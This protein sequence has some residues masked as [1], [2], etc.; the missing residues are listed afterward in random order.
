MATIGT[1]TKNVDGTFSGAINTLSLNVK[2]A[3]FRPNDKSDPKSPDFRIFAGKA[4]LGAAWRKTGENGEFLSVKLDADEG[5]GGVARG[6][7]WAALPS[8][9]GGADAAHGVNAAVGPLH[10]MGLHRRGRVGRRGRSVPPRSLAVDPGLCLFR[11]EIAPFAIA[12]QG[13]PSARR[14]GFDVATRH[15]KLADH[16]PAVGAGGTGCH[17]GFREPRF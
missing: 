6:Y 9:P 11:C 3:S 13:L 5:S 7:P 10:P 15:M 16:Y 8:S 12:G 4:E 2:A 14:A 17:S 1:F